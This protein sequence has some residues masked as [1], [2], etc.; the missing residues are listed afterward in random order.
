MRKKIIIFVVIT[1]LVVGLAG[2]FYYIHQRNIYS[3]QELKLE[4][5]AP[6]Q[7]EL[8]QEIEYT[9]RYTNNGEFRLGELLLIF[10]F[11]QYSVVEEGQS[12]RREIPLGTIYP[13]DEKQITFKGRLMGKEGDI[14]TARAWLS[15]RPA[16]LDSHYTAETSHTTQLTSVALNLRFDLPSKIEAGK[17]TTFRLNYFSNVD[18]PLSNLGVR[19]EYPSDFEFKSASPQP[20]EEPYWDIGLLNRGQGDAIEITGEIKGAA[21]E[22][23]IFRAQ[24]G[25]WQ[26]GRFVILKETNWGVEIV[27]PSLHIV[28]EINRNPQYIASPGDFLHY[29]I[30]F[31][32]L[33]SEPFT[34]LLLIAKLEGV[35]FNFNTLRV[36]L[37]DFHSASR[38][39]I[40]DRQRNPQ[41]QFLGP[42]EEGKVEF[43]IELGPQE[44]NAELK[45]RVSLGAAIEEFV[46]KIDSKL[47]LRQTIEYRTVTWELK[48]HHNDVENIKVRA[49]LAEELNLTGEII[50]G[51]AVLTFDSRSRE[52]IWI[53]EELDAGQET[54]VSFGI[55]EREE[56]P[57]DIIKISGEDQWTER[58]I[59]TVLEIEDDDE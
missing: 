17:E 26:D 40:F 51:D 22:Q 24:L 16:N 3:K 12:L 33:G 39:I 29:E 49:V 32:N 23:K 45:N 13:G 35:A 59:Q 34:D 14:K 57:F 4:I 19:V 56:K 11:P 7:T 6:R 53:V 30:I 48:N 50:P 2:L 20:L 41:L 1:A 25:F 52:I 21:G 9:V 38:S 54:S 58:I 44:K 42:Q 46:T 10:Q 8:A 15:F 18:Y 43:W 55:S 37:G 5:L 47:E 28:Q 36:P 27:I 31:R